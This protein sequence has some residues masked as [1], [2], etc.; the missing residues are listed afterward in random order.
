MQ[1]SVQQNLYMNSRPALQEM[2]HQTPVPQR[3][4]VNRQSNFLE[5]GLPNP[6]SDNTERRTVS[7]PTSRG[8][9][10]PEW[11]GRQSLS[12]DTLNSKSMTLPARIK[13]SQENSPREMSSFDSDNSPRTRTSKSGLPEAGDPVPPS[14]SP[15]SGIHSPRLCL[16]Q[17]PKKPLIH[18]ISPPKENSGHQPYKGISRPT[19]EG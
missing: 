13:Y 3:N 7:R 16:N 9:V 10:S 8:P 17:A 15:V 14:P 6:T 2:N 5:A 11:M 19:L 4:S 12:K 18:Q 1:E